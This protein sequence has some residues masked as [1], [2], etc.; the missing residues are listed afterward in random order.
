MFGKGVVSLGSAIAVGRI[1]QIIAALTLIRNL[2]PYQMGVVG[3]LTAVFIGVYSLSNLGFDRYL[4]H[5][6]DEK[7]LS[8]T[9]FDNI[10]SLQVIR[11]SLVLLLCIVLSIIIPSHSEFSTEIS[12]QLIFI[13]VAL[14]IHNFS[15]P[16]FVMYERNGVFNCLAACRGISI[17]LSSL[18]MIILIQFIADPWVYVIGQLVNT[19][20]YTVITYVLSKQLPAFRL[21][22]KISKDVFNYCKYLLLIAV[23]SFIAVQFESFY[24]GFVFGVVALGYYFTWGRVIFLPREI[25]A[26]FIDKILF[27]K[28]CSSRRNGECVARE[29]LILL[30][31]SLALLSPFYFFTWHYGEWMISIIAGEEWAEYLWVGK[32]FIIIGVFQLVA[33]LFSPLVLSMYPKISSV[34]RSVETIILVFLMILLG[35]VYGIEGV[36]LASMFVAIIACCIRVYISYRYILNNNWYWHLKW[37]VGACVLLFAYLWGAE[38]I[39]GGASISNTPN[40]SI[41]VNYVFYYLLTAFVAYKTFRH[42]SIQGKN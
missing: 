37:F 13:G 31:F 11:G 25:I 17:S 41:L 34:I 7:V 15:N 21:D 18:V 16:H 36:L 10:W 23:V 33:L 14:L 3:L 5:A 29:H 42:V 6:D 40:K 9:V 1:L 2:S 39:L 4:I 22:L 27:T 26:Q 35:Q 28:A 30:V 20:V 19:S 8:N 12:P 38:F 24:V 32:F